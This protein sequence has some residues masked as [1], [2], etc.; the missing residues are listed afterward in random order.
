MIQ[1]NWYS[2]LVKPAETLC[3]CSQIIDLSSL[4]EEVVEDT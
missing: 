2:R 4:E 3:I 1:L